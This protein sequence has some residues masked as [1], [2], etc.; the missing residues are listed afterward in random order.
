[1]VIW[2]TYDP[3]YEIEIT[4]QK[5]HTKK[6]STSLIIKCQMIILKNK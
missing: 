6:K 2:L 1:M 4:Q 3:G 5:T